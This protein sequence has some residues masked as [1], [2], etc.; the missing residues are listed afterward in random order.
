MIYKTFCGKHIDLSKLVSIQDTYIR[1]NSDS[2]RYFVCYKMYF[3]LMDNP[4]RHYK[5][6]ETFLHEE[7]SH[8]LTK[9]YQLGEIS[10]YDFVQKKGDEI[11]AVMQKQVDEIIKAW[12]DFR[13]RKT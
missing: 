4:I 11:K 1:F 10:A 5:E 9:E 3:Q 6:L 12:K 7:A 2:K 8:I 13:E